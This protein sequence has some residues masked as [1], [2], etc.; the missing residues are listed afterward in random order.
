MAYLC[1]GMV[2]RVLLSGVRVPRMVARAV[3]GYPGW[4]L[5]QLGWLLGRLLGYP[6]WLLWCC[7]AV[8]RVLGVCWVLLSGC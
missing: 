3:L 1:D 5:G 7:Y 2:A 8:A 4:L 6:G